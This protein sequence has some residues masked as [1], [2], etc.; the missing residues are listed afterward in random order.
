MPN[1][2]CRT[3]VENEEDPVE[4]RP[5]SDHRFFIVLGVEKPESKFRPPFSVTF[6]WISAT[7]LI[8]IESAVSGSYPMYVA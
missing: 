5:P 6:S 7:V 3:Y 4:V 8:E 1:R 2:R